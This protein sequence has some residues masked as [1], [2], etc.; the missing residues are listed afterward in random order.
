MLAKV[1]SLYNEFIRI[2][3]K[4]FTPQEVLLIK[5]AYKIAEDLHRG[6]LRKSGEPYIIHPLYVAYII[7]AEA[8]FYDVNTVIGGLLHD[9]IEDAGIDY[10]FISKEFDDD[11]AN[12]VQGVTNVEDV[13]YGFKKEQDL[14][15]VL[16]V[17]SSILKDFRIAI[18]KT[19]DRLHNM[20]TLEFMSPEKQRYKS[21]ETLSIYCPIALH[22]GMN[23]IKDE[24]IDLSFKYLSSTTGVELSRNNYDLIVEKRRQF[25]IN[26]QEMIEGYEKQIEDI[27]ASKG[28]GARV[29]AHVKSN[30]TI[31]QS[32]AKYRDI[33]D[34]PNVLSFQ[35]ETNCQEECYL[36]AQALREALGELPQYT[37]DYIKNPDPNGYMALHFS[38]MAQKNMLVRLKIFSKSMGEINR[39]GL[40]TLVGDSRSSVIDIQEKLQTSNAFMKALRENYQFSDNPFM[41]I[42]MVIRNIIET[43]IT[44]YDTQGCAHE[45]PN[46]STVYDYACSLTSGLDKDAIGARVNGVE[47]PLEFLVR[48]GD[49]IEILTDR[50]GKNALRVREMV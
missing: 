34:I 38:I 42:Q 26:N 33:N 46:M 43:K 45:L 17:L 15:D 30:F 32:L 6:Q 20:R 36:V 37:K 5:K 13:K 27:L 16:R 44:V 47:V 11:V 7:V 2:V 19:G 10:L 40:P 22:L 21:A 23:A 29:V 25:I 41:F 31:Y 50:K 14:Y 9:T 48:S 28:L 35:V 1:E 39:Y 4:H 18:I 49:A 3:S 12:L 24:L 8:R